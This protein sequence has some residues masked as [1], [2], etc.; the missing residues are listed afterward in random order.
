MIIKSLLI[1]DSE[2]LQSVERVPVYLYL[3][4]FI[5][6]LGQSRVSSVRNLMY[7][8]LFFSDKKYQ[9]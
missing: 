1:G 2:F 8:N 9:E 7:V 5:L 3:V 6:K 4:T